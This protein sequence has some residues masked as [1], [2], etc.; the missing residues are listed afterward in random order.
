M[1]NRIGWIL[2]VSMIG[3]LHVYTTQAGSIVSS[4][5]A[6]LCCV[7]Y[8]PRTNQG[9]KPLLQETVEEISAISVWSVVH[10]HNSAK[11]LHL[12]HAK[13]IIENWNNRIGK[14]RPYTCGR[15]AKIAAIGIRSSLQPQS[16]ENER[17]FETVRGRW[18]HRSRDI[19]F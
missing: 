15:P 9:A 10:K 7:G 8:C 18:I 4:A 19:D 12:N 14:S 2:P 3:I 11:R 6:A 17:V 16:G 5:G 13:E 1:T